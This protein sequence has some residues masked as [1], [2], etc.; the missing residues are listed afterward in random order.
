[1][2]LSIAAVDGVLRSAS[3]LTAQA[4]WLGE[5]AVGAHQIRPLTL[6]NNTPLPLPFCWQLRDAPTQ[7]TPQ[8][9]TPWWQCESS[10]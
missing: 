4:L 9:L 8:A 6:Q 1:M 7:G 3:E 10:W 5:A 2:Q